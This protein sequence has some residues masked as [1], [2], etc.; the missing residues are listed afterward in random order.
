HP[1]DHAL[2]ESGCGGTEQPRMGDLCL[3][4]NARDD[5]LEVRI[6]MG[7]EAL[8][9]GAKVAQAWLSI[10]RLDEPVL[11]AVSVAGESV[12]ALS[13]VACECVPLVA[14]E[15]TLLRRVHDISELAIRFSQVADLVLWVDEVVARVDA[16]VLLD[17]QGA[18]A[19]FGRRAHLG[20]LAHPLSD[21]RL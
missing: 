21:G 16:A 2:H 6:G 9:P 17:S 10:G 3:A 5:P 13:T 11:G 19:D 7:E 14:A 15:P 20:R 8:K 1:H 4:M 18:P 12:A